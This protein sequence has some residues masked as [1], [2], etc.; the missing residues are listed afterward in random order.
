MVDRG[1]GAI[2]NVGSKAA[3]APGVAGHSLY[4]GAKS[5]TVSFSQSLAAELKGT[6]VTVTC[7]GFT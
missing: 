7:P 3:F 2:V 5:L 4:P 6:G 1:R